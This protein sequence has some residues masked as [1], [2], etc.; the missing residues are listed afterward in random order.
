MIKKSDKVVFPS[1]CCPY[2]KNLPVYSNVNARHSVQISSF[3][4]IQSSDTHSYFLRFQRLAF[5]PLKASPRHCT[6][7]NT[8]EYR[9]KGWNHAQRFKLTTTRQKH[10]PASASIARLMTPHHAIPLTPVHARARFGAGV[11][12]VRRFALSIF[13]KH[14]L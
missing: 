12:R 11:A 14:M 2:H 6:A 4:A 10:Q 1:R 7:L 8:I 3:R 13:A 5:F 9:Y